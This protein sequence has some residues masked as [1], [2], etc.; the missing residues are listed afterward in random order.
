[1]NFWKENW[2]P[3][4]GQLIVDGPLKNLYAPD[5]NNAR[6]FLRG[7]PKE[8]AG[9]YQDQDTNMSKLGGKYLDR[10]INRVTKRVL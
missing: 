10:C 1:M 9:S 4:N 3:C 7:G 5:L 6:R 8:A 2:I